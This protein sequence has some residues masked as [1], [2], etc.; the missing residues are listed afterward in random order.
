LA[1]N[2]HDM[3]PQHRLPR[4]ILSASLL[5]ALILALTAAAAAPARVVAV[6]DVHGAYAEFT[7]L[8]Q[9]TGLIDGSLRWIGG[10]ATLVQTGDVLD[11]GAE[12]RRCL[13]LV[14]ALELR[15]ARNGG[16]LIALLGNHEVMNVMGDVRYVTPAIYGT[17]ADDGSE[18]RRAQ[19]YT[20]YLEFLAAHSGH[21]HT[22]IA[23]A[24]D[25]ARQAWMDQHPPGFFEY[26]DAFGPKGEYGRWIRSHHAVVQLG[27]GLFVHGGLNPALAFGSVR[28]LD[29]RVMSEV[30]AFDS[31]W[32]TLSESKT[33]WRYMTLT[34][35]LQFVDE[36]LA[37]L[38][39][40]GTTAQPDV[41]KAMQQLA[42]CRNWMAVS[43]DG[44]LWY[45]GLAQQPEERLL[46]GVTAMLDRLHARYIVAGHTVTSKTDVTARFG[47]RVFLLDTGMLK[48]IYGGRASALEIQSGKFTV[49]SADGE[50]R[51]LA[52]PPVQ[53][54]PPK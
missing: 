49:Y 16:T 33:V 41:V 44:P 48:E 42:G 43:S 35:A 9:R 26:R 10:T 28:D 5:V 39:A 14:M 50:P 51:T 34:E 53:A 11:R 8:L 12:S 7:A 46:A 6:A 52:G 40:G 54:Q 25:A 23:P 1:E 19:A 36:E 30:A 37:R 27:D 29:A 47:N 3:A 45:R 24:G 15:A 17:F 4:R 18:K 38:Q 21:G 31:I 32:K 13:D 2:A 22:A 20:E